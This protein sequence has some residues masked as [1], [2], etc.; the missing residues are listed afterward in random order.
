MK[1]T[2]SLAILLAVSLAGCVT[3]PTDNSAA[4]QQ[5]LTD[6]FSNATQEQPY[7]IA[8]L[9]LVDF[10]TEEQ[11]A[12][13]SYLSSD[14]IFEITR[15]FPDRFTILERDLIESILSEFEFSLMSGMISEDEV[16]QFGR[17]SGADYLIIGT[18]LELAESIQVNLRL[19]DV[20]SAEIIGVARVDLAME[21]KYATLID[22]GAVAATGSAAPAQVP[23]S[24][25]GGST[26]SGAAPAVEHSE[27]GATPFAEFILTGGEQLASFSFDES[28]D[29][30]G[31]EYGEGV[32]LDGGTV[33]T[34]APAGSGTGWEVPDTVPAP[35]IVGFDLRFGERVNE[36]HPRIH[37]NLFSTRRQRLCI[38][39]EPWGMGSFA[40]IGET[41]VDGAW[42]DYPIPEN[43]WFHVDFVLTAENVVVYVDGEMAA[44]IMVPEELN[45]DGG[46]T[47]ECHQEYWVDNLDIRRFSSIQ[48]R[49]GAIIPG[50]NVGPIDDSVYLNGRDMAIHIPYGGPMVL[51]EDLTI[52]ALFYVEEFMSD[53]RPCGFMP[54]TIHGIISQSSDVS[55][56]GNYSLGIS[57]HGAF[58][59]FEPVDSHYV[60]EADLEPNRWYHLAVSH[61]FG[62][63]EDT[64]MLINGQ[65]FPGRWFDDDGTPIDGNDRIDRISRD[66]PYM[67][68]RI[69]DENPTSRQFFAGAID[70][71]RVWNRRRSPAEIARDMTRSLD[72]SERG[73]VANFTFDE[74]LTSLD[75]T[76]QAVPIQPLRLDRP[77]IGVF[78]ARGDSNLYSVPIR[79]G[80]RY[81]VRIH[82]EWSGY[83]GNADVNNVHLYY[84]ERP[85]MPPE[86]DDPIAVFDSQ[87]RV[88]DPYVLAADRDGYLLLYTQSDS[89]GERSYEISVSEL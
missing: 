72:G 48:W 17:M 49:G 6:I 18:K 64:V 77:T 5:G 81:E 13:S 47:F 59:M 43:Q 70:E 19:V 71:L 62:N 45:A 51:T 26:G 20:E 88:D 1:S 46:V 2:T 63:G 16:A 68:G 4:F 85:E 28:L 82:D 8:V 83:E 78:Y 67:I 76:Y 61:S 66:R 14:V 25:A 44:A 54:G 12:L 42:S 41:N 24:D 52:E 37:L 55:S 69:C 27:A 84:S 11:D 40:R 15:N 33:H 30:S 31:I 58:F 36:G 65:V 35:A 89:P 23:S 53:N 50:A 34:R 56:A 73:L 3:A 80:R 79:R 75:R 74:G 38:M 21:E 86:L 87:D 57:Q 9:P 29:D 39:F 32:S 60:V 7:K 10:R 22:E